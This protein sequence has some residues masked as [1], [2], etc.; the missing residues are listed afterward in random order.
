MIGGYAAA[1]VPPPTKRRSVGQSGAP[2]AAAAAQPAQ[3]GARGGGATPGR[4]ARP[5]TSS[6]SPY[7]SRDDSECIEPLTRE[8]SVHVIVVD[9]ASSDGSLAALAGLPATMLPMTENGGFAH[10]CN[11]GL[12]R[13][14]SPRTSSFST[15]THGSTPT[16]SARLVSRARRERPRRARRAA[17]R[18]RRGG[19]SSTRSGASRGSRSTFAQALFLHR[20]F[21]GRPGPT[22]SSATRTRYE[23]AGVVEWVSGAC[24]LVRRTAFEAIGGFDEGFFLYCEDIDLC[25]RLWS[26]RCRGALR[27][28]GDRPAHR[29]RVRAARPRIPILAAERIRYARE[30]P[31]PAW[32]L[33]P[34]GP[35]SLSARS[36]TSRCGPDGAG[37]GACVSRANTARRS[38]VKSARGIDGSGLPTGSAR[39]PCAGSAE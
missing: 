14:A 8:D 19:R 32:P 31:A 27:A 6:S 2:R 35:A 39:E 34:S 24:M 13:R 38:A 28:G 4:S 25:R 5:S 11:A 23:R 22:R 20:L 18:G 21:R 7:N 1:A 12:E 30:A 3:A 9:N 17:D 29:R 37:Q 10:G 15:P 26:G 33:Q 36:R 16:R